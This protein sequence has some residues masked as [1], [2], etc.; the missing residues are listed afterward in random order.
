MLGSL[1]GDIQMDLGLVSKTNMFSDD[2]KEVMALEDI[3]EEQ[4]TWQVVQLR[5]C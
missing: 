5:L 4:V 2:F 3:E 1:G